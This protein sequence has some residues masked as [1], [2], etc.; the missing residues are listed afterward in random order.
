M[1]ILCLTPNIALDRTLTVPRVA[2]G[3]VSRATRVRETAGGKGL[4]V[5]RALVS[6]GAAVLAAGPLGGATGARVAALASAEGLTLNPTAIAGE[7]RTCTILVGAG[8]PATVIN[9]PGPLLSAGEWELLIRDTRRLAR[10]TSAVVISGS[11]PPQAPPGV[12]GRLLQELADTGA[13]LWI[14]TSGAALADAMASGAS[15]IK[16]NAEEAAAL[17]ALPV[18]DACQAKHAA[19]TMLGRGAELVTITL[20]AAG[21]VLVGSGEAW[22]AEPPAIVAANEVASGDCFLAGLVLGLTRGMPAAEALRLAT[23]CGTANAEA[24]G[25]GRLDPER[26]AAIADATRIVRLDRSL[27][28]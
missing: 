11:L 19:E 4:N 9:E 3:Q 6:M 23:A 2:I 25:A 24:G 14:D 26:V 12:F 5:A 8:G 13:T 21:A 22:S 17:T 1:T 16:V 18:H 10:D 15:R 27:R 20:G 28:R 7:T